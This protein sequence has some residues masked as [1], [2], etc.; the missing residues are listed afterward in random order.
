MADHRVRV[1]YE[2]QSKRQHAE[3]RCACGRTVVIS[4]KVIVEM[5]P[6]VLPLDQAAKRLRCTRC[7]KRQ[8]TMAGVHREHRG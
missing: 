8:A 2:F 1:V 5:F 3:I 7:G 4:P 6:P